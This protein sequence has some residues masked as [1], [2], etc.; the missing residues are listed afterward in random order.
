MESFCIDGL[1]FNNFDLAIH[2]KLD[3]KQRSMIKKYLHISFL[4]VPAEVDQDKIT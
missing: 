3:Y 1:H 4:N 2:F